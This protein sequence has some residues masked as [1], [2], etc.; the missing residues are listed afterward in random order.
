MLR[1]SGVTPWMR[2]GQFWLPAITWALPVTTGLSAVRAGDLVL[3]RR[4]VG[5]LE[6]RDGARAAADAAALRAAGLDRQHVGAEA[7]KLALTEALAPWP[8][9][10]MAMTAA[11]P[12]MMPSVVSTAAALVGAQRRQRRGQAL[13]KHRRHPGAERLPAA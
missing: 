10:T 9:A 3:D 12:M 7:G 6:G 2:V 11:T 4:G 1:Y 13:A 8:S 5:R